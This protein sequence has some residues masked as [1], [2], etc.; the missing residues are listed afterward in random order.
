VAQLKK[1]CEEKGEEYAKTE[2]QE[3]GA[4]AKRIVQENVKNVTMAHEKE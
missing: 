2:I 4:K 1:D 3:F